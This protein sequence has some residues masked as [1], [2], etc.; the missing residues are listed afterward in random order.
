[1]SPHA[2]SSSSHALLSISTVF[3]GM[4]DIASPSPSASQPHAPNTIVEPIVVDVSAE[5]LAHFLDLLSIPEI[6]TVSETELDIGQVC[7]LAKFADKY[8]AEGVRSLMD[9][10]LDRINAWKLLQYA[11]EI[12]DVELARRAIRR[13]PLVRKYTKTDDTFKIPEFWTEMAKLQ[14]CWQ[15]ALSRQFFAS[16][17][18]GGMGHGRPWV[19]G[20]ADRC[21]LAKIAA[22]FQ[23]ATSS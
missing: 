4:F 3:R 23:P 12:N 7:Q 16:V 15:V 21:D 13:L 17:Q 11:S 14:I 20:T 22:A 10:G 8:D 5:I 19:R 2:F 1:M 6:V 18:G 9:E